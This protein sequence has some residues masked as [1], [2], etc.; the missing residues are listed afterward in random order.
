MSAPCL[1]TAIATTADDFSIELA[2]TAAQRREA[3]RVRHQV[4]CVERGYEA[5]D[6]DIETDEFDANARHVLLRHRASGE[7]VGTVRLVMPRRRH[8]RDSFPMQ[9]VCDPSAFDAVPLRTSAEISRFALSKNRRLGFDQA[10]G[11][12]RLALVRGLVQV[13]DASGLTHWCAVMERSLLRLLRMTAIHLE[14]TGP[15]VEY[16][17]MRQPATC[18]VDVM[19]GR[20]RSENA[21]VWNYLTQGGR[22]WAPQV[23]AMTA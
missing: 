1:A 10:G 17:G 5:C 4:Y 15:L 3:F 9:R 13:S 14:P 8:L 16:H 23:E 11:L 20:V 12:M 2:D 7:V 18:D 21:P 22:L 6:D 19:L